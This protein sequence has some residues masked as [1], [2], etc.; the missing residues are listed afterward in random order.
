M[1]KPTPKQELIRKIIA[2]AGSQFV[3]VGFVKKNGERRFVTFNP[4]DFNEIKG[5]G[6]ASTNPDI[7]KV[8]EVQNAE[9]GKTTWRSFSIDRLF[10]IKAN[11]NEVTFKEANNAAH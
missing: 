5:T 3:R 4:R 7:I 11:G 1:A 8:R 6:K 9:E 10:S 2:D